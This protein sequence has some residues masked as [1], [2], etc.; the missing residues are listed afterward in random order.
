MDE[1]EDVQKQLNRLGELGEYKESKV[2]DYSVI[3]KDEMNKIN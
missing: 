1:F 3:K 2:V